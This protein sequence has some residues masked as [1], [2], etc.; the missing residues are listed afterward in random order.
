MKWKRVV[1]YTIK[2]KNGFHVILVKESIRFNYIIDVEKANA[3]AKNRFGE[4]HIEVVL[5]QGGDI[6]IPG[7]IQA[8]FNVHFIDDL[9]CF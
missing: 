6:P 9:C 8:G 4:D 3:D 7:T 1:Y 5:N 2:T